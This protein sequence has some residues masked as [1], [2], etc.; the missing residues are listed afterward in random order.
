MSSAISRRHFLAGLGAAAAASAASSLPA[1]SLFEPPLYPPTDLSYFDT[2]ISAAPSEIHLGYAAI[3]W[4]GNDRQA[5][6]DISDLGFPGIQLRANVI[7]EFSSAGELKELLQRH[8]LTMVALS[9]GGVPIDPSGQADELAKHTANARFVHDLDG[10]YLQV[11]DQKPKNRA[12][13]AADYKQLGRVLT[14]LGKRTAEE[15]GRHGG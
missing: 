12:V 13:A 4:N 11:T 14:E 10:L 1:W 6:E 2:P 3:T 5:I 9:S 8:K 7:K 15:K